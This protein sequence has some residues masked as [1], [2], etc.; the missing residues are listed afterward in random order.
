MHTVKGIAMDDD[1]HYITGHD[2]EA[3]ARCFVT[4][5]HDDMAEEGEKSFCSIEGE[6]DLMHIY[7][8]EISSVPLL[9]K[10]GE[11][12]IAKKIE[13]GKEKIFGT[14]FSLPFFQKRLLSLGKMVVN[15]ELSLASVVQHTE[16]DSAEDPVMKGKQFFCTHER[17][18]FSL[19][20]KGKIPEKTERKCACHYRRSAPQATVI[21]K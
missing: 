3:D 19:S 10:E 20:E 17:N 21:E 8:K 4:E 6:K 2:K 1:L 16:D 13:E 11:I 12:E 9:T 14:I 7:L 18:R 15:G 5:A